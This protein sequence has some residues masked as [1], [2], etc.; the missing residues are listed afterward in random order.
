[1]TRK[2]FYSIIILVA[3]FAT[4]FV[5]GA[6]AQVSVSPTTMNLKVGQKATLT[7]NS[8]DAYNLTSTNSGVATISRPSSYNTDTFTVT[9]VAPGTTK[10]QVRTSQ[11]LVPAV[12]ECTVTVS[13]NTP[14]VWPTSAT[15]EYPALT[16]KVGQ[17]FSIRA[18][19]LP[20]NYNQGTPRWSFDKPGI[21][22]ATPN[23]LSA[24][25][26]GLA[27][28][29]TTLTF[30]IGNATASCVLTIVPNAQPQPN[31]QTI[32]AIVI[33]P[34]SIELYAGDRCQFRAKAQPEGAALPAGLTW[35]ITQGTSVAKILRTE[36]ADCWIDALRPGRATITLTAGN[37]KAEAPIY[38]K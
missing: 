2:A 30:T 12:A 19:V 37:L 23:G 33:E 20:E 1:M 25:L 15:L 7:V 17:R 4:M 18:T 16:L 29:V 13:N 6:Y 22:S 10:I 9:A 11:A 32:K 3:F 14:D 28:G 31:P 36:A 35:K 21:A 5:T 8:S 38:V 24:N 26:E 34:A 27:P